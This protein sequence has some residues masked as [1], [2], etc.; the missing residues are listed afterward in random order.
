MNPSLRCPASC[1]VLLLFVLFFLKIPEYRDNG[2]MDDNFSISSDNFFLPSHHSSAPPLTERLARCTPS[3]HCHLC[4]R[5]SSP[6]SPF[7]HALSFSGSQPCGPGLM[8]WGGPDTYGIKSSRP[9][10]GLFPLGIAGLF[11]DWLIS[12]RSWSKERKYR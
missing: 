1:H 4:P 9:I 8:C 7:F 10:F 6:S 11:F 3:F 5:A 2:E 12:K